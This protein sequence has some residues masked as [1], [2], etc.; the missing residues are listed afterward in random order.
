[1]TRAP[2]TTGKWRPDVVDYLVTGGLAALGWGLWQ[3][4]PPA[5]LIV[6]GGLLFG[7]G[8][9]LLGARHPQG[10]RRPD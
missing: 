7:L 5:A 6:V 10:P 3:V 9:H 4:Y 8:V 2:E 1:M